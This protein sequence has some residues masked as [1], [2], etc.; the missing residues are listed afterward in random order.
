MT[1]QNYLIIESNIVTNVCVWDGD[2]STWTPPADS[3][4]LVQATTPAL[5]WSLD[6]TTSPS[7]WKL[8]EQIGIADIG[9][10]W[11]GTVCTTN[12]PKPEPATPAINQPTTTGTKT[13]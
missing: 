7:S 8:V 13:I 3:I 12:V 10:I 2:V 5:V 11:D 9:F 6:T 1:T 4:Q